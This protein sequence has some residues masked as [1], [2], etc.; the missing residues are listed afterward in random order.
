MCFFVARLLVLQVGAIVYVG[1]MWSK[2][3]ELGLDGPASIPGMK[4]V[5]RFVGD[6]GA[7]LFRQVK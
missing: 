1:L 5:K 7:M 4:E 3:D 2:R 6:G